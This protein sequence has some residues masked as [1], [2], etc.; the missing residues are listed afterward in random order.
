MSISNVIFDTLICNSWTKWFRWFS[1]W[2]YE[3]SFD[4]I[5]HYAH[6][7]SCLGRNLFCNMAKYLSLIHFR[8]HSVM[9]VHCI[10]IL[11]CIYRL[12][13]CNNRLLCKHGQIKLLKIWLLM[14]M[15]GVYIEVVEWSAWY[16]NCFRFKYRALGRLKVKMVGCLDVARSHSSTVKT[17]DASKS[18]GDSKRL[19]Y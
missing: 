10:S 17:D 11:C 16:I 15:S 4:A 14:L 3:W 1:W 13:S 2:S 18:E 8:S 7:T 19:L 6:D 5:F 12:P 9:M